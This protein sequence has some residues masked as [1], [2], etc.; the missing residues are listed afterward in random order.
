MG[1]NVL[2]GPFVVIGEPC[3]FHPHDSRRN[4]ILLAPTRLPLCCHGA[5][6]SGLLPH[7]PNCG[8]LHA[9]LYL[10]SAASYSL[11]SRCHCYTLRSTV[12]PCPTRRQLNNS[13]RL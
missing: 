9:L 10:F 7:E 4:P 12:V 1:T 3:V 8:P 5:C 6:W 13:S 11:R 2:R